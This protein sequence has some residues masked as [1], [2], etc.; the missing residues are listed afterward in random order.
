CLQASRSIFRSP[1]Y[2]IGYGGFLGL[3][4]KFPEFVEQVENICDEFRE[5]H[6]TIKG[7]KEYVAPFKICVLN[8]WGILRSWQTLQVAH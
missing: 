6:E 8:C 5:I 7:T 2:R 4:V 1:L 3:A